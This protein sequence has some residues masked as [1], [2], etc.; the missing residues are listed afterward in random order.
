LIIL[1]GAIAFK[2][3]VFKERLGSGAFGV[4][5]LGEYRLTK[6]AIKQLKPGAIDESRVADF[7]AEMEL[8]TSLRPHPNIIQV[9]FSLFCSIEFQ[10][11][12]KFS[13]E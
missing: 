12:W 13:E 1:V 4:V 6:V 10:R 11:L 5:Y 7:K 9:N 2:E 3:L 8:M